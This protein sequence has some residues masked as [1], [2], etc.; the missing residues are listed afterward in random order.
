MIA[1]NIVLKVSNLIV[2]VDLFTNNKL[3]YEKI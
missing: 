2:K 1:H 3:V